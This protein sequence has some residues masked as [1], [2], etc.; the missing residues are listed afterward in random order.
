MVPL[1]MTHLHC[2]QHSLFEHLFNLYTRRYLA[3]SAVPSFL[4]ARQYSFSSAA[5]W[6][7]F[8]VSSIVLTTFLISALSHTIC[9][10]RNGL[11][12]SSLHVRSARSSMFPTTWL[13]IAHVTVH[14]RASSEF[15]KA[16][17]PVCLLAA[18]ALTSAPE[19][20]LLESSRIV[21]FCSLYTEC[22]I[23]KRLLQTRVCFINIDQVEV[24][25]HHPSCVVWPVH[26]KKHWTKHTPISVRTV[27]PQ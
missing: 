18:S 17:I 25:P 23:S 14:L 15:V 13:R 19:P 20:Y 26:G 16:A 5:I 6:N 9:D 11:V 21:F 27:V 22:T 1:N 12:K 4:V 3:V 2:L 10:L 24:I 8:I 7:G